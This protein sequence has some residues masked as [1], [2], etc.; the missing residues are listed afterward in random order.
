MTDTERKIFRLEDDIRILNQHL[1][2]EERPYRY[3]LVKS[4]EKRAADIA[5]LRNRIA[6][7]EEELKQL[8]NQ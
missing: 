4:D 6:E 3:S 2:F 8:Q 7:K 5:F 1:S